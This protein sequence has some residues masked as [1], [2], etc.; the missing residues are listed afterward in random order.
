MHT[1]V[2]IYNSYLSKAALL[3]IF[4]YILNSLAHFL[5]W[6][7]IFWWFDM[8]MHF[9]GGYFIALLFVSICKHSRVVEY[10]A[11]WNKNTWI[12]SIISAV[13]CV[14]ILWE[15]FE[16]G[17]QFA[18]SISNIA[19]VTDSFSDLFFDTLGGLVFLFRR[20]FKNDI[21]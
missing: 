10:T 15:F 20:Y 4:I 3:L 19:T 21:L 18:F 8:F 9:L 14:G 5:N 11:H 1:K 17:L 7:Y 12:V 16:W 6:Y 13:I 2:S